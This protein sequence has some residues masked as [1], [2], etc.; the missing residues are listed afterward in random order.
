MKFSVIVPVYN[1]EKYIKDCI[2]SILNQSYNNFE[3]II[4]NDGSYDKSKQIIETYK[5]K[6]I[7]LYNKKN[8]GIADTRNFAISKCSSDY[9]IFV[10]SD[11][12]INKDL[13]LTLKNNL[14]KEKVD[15]IK[16]QIQMIYPNGKIKYNNASVFDKL[17]GEEAFPILIKNNLFVSTVVYAYKLDYF[18][19]N[20]Y[21][22]LIGNVYED[23][24]LTPI[25]VVNAK[26]I[27]CINYI[28][29]N[30]YVR[31]NSIMTS[32]KNIMSSRNKDAINQ[33]DR[34]MEMINNSSVSYETKK[35]F[36]SYIC[37]A[38]INRCKDMNGKILKDY[39]NILNNKKIYKYLI[40]DTLI[41]KIKKFIFKYIPYLYIKIILR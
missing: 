30:Y 11:D 27:K 5:D 26:S 32:S 36:K 8:T 14:E 31:E 2:D 39:V 15:L 7:K 4:V 3:L 9:F 21:K 19:N 29:Y 23:F 34:L 12:T 35:L 40:D 17:S 13:L 20:N 6:R 16:F 18:K 10:D 41:R 1:T 37:N 24:G 25:V 22:Y 28:G 33:F 38:M